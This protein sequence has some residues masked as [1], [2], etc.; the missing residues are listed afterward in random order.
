MTTPI[1]DRLA[2]L[3]SQ[4]TTRTDRLVST[5]HALLAQLEKTA[6]VD[7]GVT[8][9]GYTLR[10]VRVR[11]NVGAD[12]FWRLSSGEGEYGVIS[13]YLDLEVG[14]D[15]YLHGDFNASIQGPSRADLIW[16]AQRADK[17]V[18]AL[19]A[20]REATNAALEVAEKSAAREV[21]S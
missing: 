9:D 18:A 19:V 17:F 7:E 2:Q 12:F 11:S 13:C 16:F 4:R 14:A 6:E 10:Y 21:V 8:V 5:V 3:A 1:L 20:Q 15:R